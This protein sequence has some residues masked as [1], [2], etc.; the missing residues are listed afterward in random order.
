MREAADR[1]EELEIAL[2]DIGSL[3]DQQG[4]YATGDT[5]LLVKVGEIARAILGAKAQK[6]KP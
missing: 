3:A 4:S 6:E 5:P 2:R 1:I